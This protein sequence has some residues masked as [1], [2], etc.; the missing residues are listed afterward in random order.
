VEYNILGRTALRV[1]RIGFGCGNIGGLMVRGTA[2]DQE[3]A[4]ARAL[5]LGINYFDTAPQY[6]NTESETNLGRVL[7]TL[8]P[9]IVLA[10]KTH[11]DPEQRG[12]IGA[13]I[14]QSCEAS[15]RRLRRERV[16]VFQL[17]TAV[18]LAGGNGTLDVQTA[19][20]EAIPAF[21]AL[22]K[23]GKVGFYG[24]S[25]TGEAAAIPQLIA[26]GA[27]DVF[28]VIYN[29]LN[30]SA[31]NGTFAAIGANYGNVL[32]RAAE[33]RMGAVG[34]RVLAGGALSSETTRHAV[35]SQNVVPMGTSA[36]YRGDVEGAARLAALVQEG[37]VATLAEAALRFAITNPTIS[38]ALV[39]FSDIAQVEAAAAAE[40]KGPLPSKALNRIAA[41]LPPRHPELV[42]GQR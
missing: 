31:G 38:S 40:S 24:F 10:T 33:Q 25:G 35:S 22:R 1:S 19:I 37:H 12:K 2:A 7:A 27:F 8:R 17:H 39:G 34:I 18:T 36:D 5:E 20:E 3:R 29:I 28:Q 41:L 16:D 23:A 21:E 11:A 32:A 14:A 13:G 4:V 9:D 26:T 42:E 6:G 15:L 30:P